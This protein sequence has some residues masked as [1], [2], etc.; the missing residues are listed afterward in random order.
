[1]SLTSDRR[2]RIH[3]VLTDALAKPPEQRDAFIAGAC[4]DDAEVRAEVESMLAHDEQAGEA[5]MQVPEPDARFSLRGLS[6]GPDPRISTSVGGYRI[7]SVIASGGMGTVYEAIQEEPHRVVALKIMRQKVASRSALR[8][9]QFESQILARLRHPNV[10][11][12]FVAGTHDDGAGSVPYFAMEYVPDARTIS[13]YASEK[14]LTIRE[15]LEL[16]TQVCGAVHHGHQNG[17]IHRDLKPGNILVDPS[18]QVKIIDFGVARSTD[19]D[20]AVT[21]MQTDVGQIIGTLQYMSP[22]QCEADPDKIDTRSDVYALGVVLYELLCDQLPYDLKRTAIHEATRI[23]REDV[24]TRPSITNRKLRGD[25]EVIVLKALEKDRERRYQSAA[26]LG[27]DIGRFLNRGPIEAR[28]PGVWMRALRWTHRRPILASTTASLVIA[29]VI[30]VATLVAVWVVNSRPHILTR[31]RAGKLIAIEDRGECDEAR[32]LAYSDRRLK[33]WG[34]PTYSIASANL[35]KRPARFGGG[36]V[37][38]IGY[39]Y[40]MIG[41]WS[42]TLCVYDL[43][44]DLDVPVWSDRIERGDVLPVL[45]EKRGMTG[46]DFFVDLAEFF[47]V[48][49]DEEHPGDEIVVVFKNRHSQ[50]LIRIYDLGGTLLYQIWH[51]GEAVS[52]YWLAKAGL[53]V[54]SGDNA[55]YNYDSA[56]NILDPQSSPFVVFAIRPQAGYFGEDEDPDYL[57]WEPG[58]GS[59]SAVWY[60]TL[61]FGKEVVRRHGKISISH[62]S[63]PFTADARR[64]T[65]LSVLVDRD[66]SAHIAWNIDKYGNEVPNSR[67]ASEVYRIDQASDNP[68]LPDPNLFSRRDFKPPPPTFQPA[69]IPQ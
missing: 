31:Y 11:Q 3:R 28:L 15:R 19:S 48:F 32:L 33:V 39:S 68:Q 53:L 4:E 10:A 66:L 12:V 40:T 18:G 17:I 7:E 42:G 26:D 25:V 41:Q 27:Q 58:S 62:L 50:R 59:A 43:D 23:I 67:E 13:E 20:M 69:T 6:D 38:L 61:C 1:M 37:A 30:V 35:A 65:R 44:G 34:G 49:P 21:T 29:L 22:E 46:E 5:F 51:E 64:F 63:A 2:E 8:R 56:G 9:F 16:F 52:P 54:F 57:K 14:K 36:K 24:P 45:Q 47:D 55:F 60:K